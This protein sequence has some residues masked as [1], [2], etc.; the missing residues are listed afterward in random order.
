MR[1][2][3]VALVLTLATLA[4]SLSIFASAVPYTPSANAWKEFGQQHNY[5]YE[6]KKGAS[7]PKIDGKLT[8]KDGYGEP[9]ATFGFRYVTTVDKVVE[10]KSKGE[11][12]IRDDGDYY[13]YPT[14][15]TDP[16][17]WN[18]IS[19][20]EIE[21]PHCFIWAY[22]YPAT[23]YSSSSTYY[24]CHPETHEFLRA[25]GVTKATF[26]NYTVRNSKS[27]ILLDD[28]TLLTSKP[29]DWNKNFASYF[30]KASSTDGYAAVVGTGTDKDVAPE[31]KADTYYSGKTTVVKQLY[32]IVQGDTA[33]SIA[34]IA[35]LKT[36]RVI[37]PE[38]INLY[39]R[40]D[41]NNLYYA[42]EVVEDDHKIAYYDVTNFFGTTMTNS[43]SYL[44]NSYDFQNYYRKSVDGE[45][46]SALA[47][48]K[49][50]TYANANPAI[51]SVEYILDKFGNPDAK[52]E[53]V[54]VAGKDYAINHTKFT[55]PAQNNDGANLDDFESSFEEED[56][57]SD[58]L[59][60]GTYGTTV[61]EFKL[62]WKVINGR[63]HPQ[64]N[65]NPIPEMLTVRQEIQLENALGGSAFPLSFSMP[66]QT[67]YLPGGL[68]RSGANYPTNF[69]CFRYMDDVGLTQGQK[70]GT[71]NFRWNITS[72][73]NV[74]SKEKYTTEYTESVWDAKG[75][76][77]THYPH[78]FFPSGAEPGDDY[79]V[80]EYVGAQI[81]ADGSE[82]QKM[83]IK[84]A[85]PETEKEIKEAGVIVVPT[86]VARRTQL[87]L[88]ISSIRY[89]AEENPFLSG[90]V[91]GKWINLNTDPEK[92]FGVSAL[93]DDS[94]SYITYDRVGGKP[95][96]IY[97]VYTLAADLENPYEEKTNAYGDSQKIYSVVFG[98]HKGEGL[99]NDFD[100]FNTFYT[101]RPYVKYEDGTV[102]Y[103]EHEY[104]SLYYLACWQ[105]QDIL[106]EYNSST[107]RT[108]NTNRYCMDE[109]PLAV[110][111]DKAGNELTDSQGNPL[112]LPSSATGA[113]VSPYS[114][115]AENSIYLAPRR[116]DVLRWYA[117]KLVSR[118][119]A[120]TPLR[121]EEYD[122]FDANTKLLVDQYTQLLEN[123]WSV[124]ETAENNRYLPAKPEVTKK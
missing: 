101:I 115:A 86:E 56:S 114:G 68:S 20:F 4:S 124:I 81:R 1:K 13:V 45:Y 90:V 59:T 37:L 71:Y 107:G 36:N 65:P 44:A 102:T 100:D 75:Y 46:S 103:G 2:R 88:G 42:I 43:P 112:Y 54:H 73:T 79:A 82:A 66:R 72:T 10:A 26:K 84:F 64:T 17:V 111:S 40:Y 113:A 74:W 52:Y 6:V 104:K 47:K 105:I 27:H 117:V 18:S 109:M 38:K 108:A 29:A 77:L 25:Y 123:V 69:S 120:N 16:E 93:P 55:P 85:I 70:F 87:K 3:I 89:Y 119:N 41:K 23:S 34:T 48:D 28:A 11:Y 12:K 94:D 8:D 83:R 92:Y 60:S 51:K 63:Y 9:V 31:W 76:T 98:G 21:N 15:E 122:Q 121:Y 95:S 53:E 78:I 14:T 96:G 5:F 57:G 19:S 99:Y 24:Y 22:R 106:D 35:H 33:G 110:V 80:P 7:L 39:A 62:P 50:K 116:L 67:A 30:T 118:R 61:Y 32:T 58:F 91:D 97:T 49:I